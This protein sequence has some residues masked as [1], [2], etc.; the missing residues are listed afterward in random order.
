MFLSNEGE[1]D[2]LNHALYLQ[3][4][5]LTVE[6]RVVDNWGAYHSNR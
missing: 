1:L 4:D 2:M 5:M 3:P 6:G